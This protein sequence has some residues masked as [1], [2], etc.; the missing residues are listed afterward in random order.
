MK[1]R[2]VA[3]HSFYK[4]VKNIKC[5]NSLGN[6]ISSVTSYNSPKEIH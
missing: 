3:D 5:N 6:I 4:K 1:A 2:K